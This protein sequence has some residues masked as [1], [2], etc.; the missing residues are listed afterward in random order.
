M[1]LVRGT[2]VDPDLKVASLVAALREI[3]AQ[4]EA[5]GSGEGVP[6][7]RA[8]ALSGVGMQLRRVAHAALQIPPASAAAETA[9]TNGQDVERAK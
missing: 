5:L 4:F 6:A 8:V 2:K 7:I 3:A 9:A 1:T